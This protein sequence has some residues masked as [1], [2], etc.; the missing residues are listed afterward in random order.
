MAKS[1]GWLDQEYVSQDAAVGLVFMEPSWKPSLNACEG[2]RFHSALTIE[3]LNFLMT[4]EFIFDF[5]ENT[6]LTFHPSTPKSK[7]ECV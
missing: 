6:I 5:I 7:T 3:R 2:L 1:R 4:V